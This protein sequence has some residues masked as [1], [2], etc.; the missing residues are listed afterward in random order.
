MT[1]VG[2]GLLVK[3]QPHR[4]SRY[5]GPPGQGRCDEQERDGA[6]QQRGGQEHGLVHEI[7]RI[8]PVPQVLGP[9]PGVL[10]LAPLGCPP[11][12]LN[13]GATIGLL[14]RPHAP[15]DASRLCRLISS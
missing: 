9:G 14:A 13:A 12:M 5:R 4:Q 1:D 2:C 7:D 3:A 8:Q 15:C 10:L 11:D 6:Q